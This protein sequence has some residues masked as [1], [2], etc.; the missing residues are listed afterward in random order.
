[1]IDLIAMSSPE[2]LRSCQ[3][4]PPLSNSDHFGIL[5]YSQWKVSNHSYGKNYRHIWCYSH[6]D[7]KLANALIANTDWSLVLTNNVNE[8]WQNWHACFMEIMHICTPQLH[9]S[10]RSNLPWLNKHLKQLMRRRNSLFQRAKRTKLKSDYGKYKRIRNR[11]LAQLRKARANYFRQLNPS[12]PKEFWKT[13]KL[14]NKCHSQPSVPV[15]TH[16]DIQASSDGG[17]SKYDR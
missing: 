11:V 1:M 7:W 12:N 10:H 3:T 8:S 6:A 2:L 16:G 4:A 17:K 15:L 14:L 13:I 5:L 9:L